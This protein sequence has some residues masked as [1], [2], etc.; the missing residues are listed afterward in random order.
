VDNV[1]PE[2]LSGHIIQSGEKFESSAGGVYLNARA[3]PYEYRKGGGE[4]DQA[5]ETTFDSIAV[6]PGVSV[7]LRKSGGQIVYQGT[8]PYMATSGHTDSAFQ[9]WLQSRRDKMPGWMRTYLDARSFIPEI[10]SGLSPGIGG[11]PTNGVVW[12]K[13]TRIP[14]TS[15]D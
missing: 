7:E 8:G 4:I 11:T 1:F 6:T 14:G 3:E 10:L 15:C 13:V 12:V 2:T 9:T 5:V